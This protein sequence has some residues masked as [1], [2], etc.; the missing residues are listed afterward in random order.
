[1]QEPPKTVPKNSTVTVKFVGA[2]LRNQHHLGMSFIKVEYYDV[3]SRKWT[4][5]YNDGWVTK[6]TY[7]P[8][9]TQL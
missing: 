6:K 4:V 3:V 9:Y 5:K 7:E 2:S 8:S 1:M